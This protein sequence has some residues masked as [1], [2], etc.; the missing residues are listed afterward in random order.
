MGFRNF[1]NKVW[2]I[3]RFIDMNVNFF[4]EHNTKV[5]VEIQKDKLNQSDREILE[6]KDRL[7]EEITKLTTPNKYIKDFQA[8]KEVMPDL[9]LVSPRHLFRMPY[10]L[11]EKTTL[12]SIVIDKDELENFDMKDA[13]PMKLSAEK[14]KNFT[15]N[16]RENEASELL[17]QALD[18]DKENSPKEEIKKRYDD[19]SEKEIENRNRL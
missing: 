9:I 10:S 13:D 8:P 6:K 18:W 11:H 16:S 17:M 15:P 7:I 4:N 5:L 14:I 1:A 19:L 12:A 3:G 2:N